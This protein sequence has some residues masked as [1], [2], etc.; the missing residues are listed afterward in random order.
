MRLAIR[1]LGLDLLTIEASTD[2]T[3]IEHADLESTWIEADPTHPV[4]FT[5]PSTEWGDDDDDS[6]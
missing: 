6:D 4:G 3:S 1:F 5:L 2:D